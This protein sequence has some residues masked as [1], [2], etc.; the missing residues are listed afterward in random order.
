MPDSPSPAPDAD[1]L[2]LKREKFAHEYILNGGNATQAAIAAGYS[3]GS[4]HVTGS[5][6]L[7]D[8][9]VSEVIDEQREQ[10][11]ARYEITEDKLLQRLAQIAFEP[12]ATDPKARFFQGPRI[13]K[14]IELLGKNK[15]M[16][17]DKVQIQAETTI[18]VIDPYAAK[19]D[20]QQ[21]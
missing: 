15:K 19:P 9:K 6:L 16:W 5:R 12:L 20:A 8:A 14:A 10:L 17:T 7:S 2:P 11:S 1:T 13:L 18:T 21:P 4:A 3:E